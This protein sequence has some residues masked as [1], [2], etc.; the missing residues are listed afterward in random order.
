[1][2]FFFSRGKDGTQVKK[3][4]TNVNKWKQKQNV[5]NNSLSFI[6]GHARE[7]RVIFLAASE[8]L[9]SADLRPTRVFLSSDLSAIKEFVKKPH[10]IENLDPTI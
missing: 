4:K 10:E 3:R 9:I 6:K 1:M 8:T 5:S 2:L 7:R